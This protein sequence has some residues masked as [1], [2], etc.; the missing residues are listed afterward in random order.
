MNKGSWS[1]NP[2]DA[3]TDEEISKILRF[4]CETQTAVN[5]NE[6]FFIAVRDPAEQEAIIG[7]AAW[8]GSTSPGTVTILILA[9]QVSNPANHKD[10]YDAKSYY[11]LNSHTIIPWLGSLLRVIYRVPFASWLFHQHEVCDPV[12][13]NIRSHP[14]HPEAHASCSL[15]RGFVHS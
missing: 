4:A 9:D 5:W 6:Y 7:D 3:P 8:K 15:Y 12:V 13:Q 10:P 14:D 2:T 11:I 1:S